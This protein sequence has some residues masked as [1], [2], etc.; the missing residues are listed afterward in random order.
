MNRSYASLN[1]SNTINFFTKLGYGVGE[2]TSEI[3]GSILVFFFLFFLTNVAGLNAGLAGII[4]LVGKIW[5]A[6]NDPIIGWLSDQTRSRWG[7]RYPW[8]AIGAIPF[9]ICFTLLWWVPST[10]SQMGLFVYYCAIALIYHIA[11]TAVVLPYATLG[12]ELTESYDE[13]TSLVSYKA[14]FSMGGNILGILIAL[15]TFSL[16]EN[17]EQRYLTV[18]T[19]GGAIAALSV[20]FCIWGT[21]KRFFQVQKK[22]NQSSRSSSFPLAQ[23]IRIVLSNRPFLLLVGLYLCS[24]LGVQVTGNMLS[25]FVTNW[26]QLPEI[27]I[28]GMALAVLGSGLVMMLLWSYLGKRVGKRIT[29]CVAVPLTLI[30]QVGLFFLQPGQVVAMYGIGMLAGAGLAVA[31][32]IP[33]SMLP[34]VID[35]DELKTGERREGIFY[36]FMV[37]LQKVAIAIAIFSVGKVL[38][39]AGFISS[40]SEQATA[41][42]Q[43]ESALLAIRW[44]IGP[45][46]SVV[47]IG[48]II[49]AL[50]YPITRP[51][52]EDILLKLSERKN[53]SPQKQ[54]ETPLESN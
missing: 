54:T 49:L 5:D 51:V 53:Q 11:F 18:G 43:P 14:G 7:R 46:P 25:Y 41:P 47:L 16:I 10:D 30:A 40:S 4:L 31:Y 21:Y 12:A 9:G 48:G 52:H 23:Q 15:G 45:I 27:H 38:D 50:M 3:T 36:G 22:R 37:H 2:F 8:M 42:A 28:P 29:Y 32:F 6:I 34:D 33:W 17:P 24:W 1:N 13:R 19:I 35:L 26:M 20:Y 44:L 39:F